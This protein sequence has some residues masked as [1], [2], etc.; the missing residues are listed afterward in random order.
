MF[1]N[2]SVAIL[3]LTF[4]MFSSIIM[5][6]HNLLNSIVILAF[7]SYL[8]S[9]IE[10]YHSRAQITIILILLPLFPFSQNLKKCVQPTHSSEISRFN[11]NKSYFDQSGI[12]CNTAKYP[13]YQDFFNSNH[14]EESR[15]TATFQT[16][17]GNFSND[18]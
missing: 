13:L 8:K 3:I 1:L 10:H 14:S 15:N 6:L 9:P 5:K 11:P 2:A 18:S 16:G 4:S 17:P 7:H 12:D